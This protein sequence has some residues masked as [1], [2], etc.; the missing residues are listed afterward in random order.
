[1]PEK[2]LPVSVI[3]STYKSKEVALK[4]LGALY[5]SSVLP[6]E[7]IVIDNDSQDARHI[8]RQRIS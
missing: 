1:M 7:V 3:I 8:P 4:A 2:K 5:N 6:E